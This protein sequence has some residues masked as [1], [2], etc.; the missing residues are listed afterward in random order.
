MMEDPSKKALSPQTI[1]SPQRIELPQSDDGSAWRSTLPELS[2]TAM[3][4][5]AVLFGKSL[6]VQFSKHELSRV[7]PAKWL[8]LSD[9][10][11]RNTIL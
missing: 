2:R 10:C 7:I 11:Q 8:R 9:F 1:E 3:G 6:L 5:S 4:E